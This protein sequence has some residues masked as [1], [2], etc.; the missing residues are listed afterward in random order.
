M[1]DYRIEIFWSDEDESYIAVI[2]ELGCGVSAF[3]D[4]P[5]HA[6]AEILIV[7][8]VVLD[9]LRDLGRPIPEPRP[10]D[11]ERITA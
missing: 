7:K 9:T 4:T 1:P 2:P 5:E 11:S 8:Q 6:L 3:G 10:S